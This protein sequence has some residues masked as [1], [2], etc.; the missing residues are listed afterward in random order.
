[1]LKKS[2]DDD[3]QKNFIHL[4]NV[5]YPHELNQGNRKKCN[6]LNFILITYLDVRLMN[7]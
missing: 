2:K 3:I 5:V 1:M 7:Y 6:R 4:L